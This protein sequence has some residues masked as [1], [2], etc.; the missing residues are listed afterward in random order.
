[1]PIFGRSFPSKSHPFGVIASP[2]FNGV[3]ETIDNQGTASYTLSTSEAEPTNQ[4]GNATQALTVEATREPNKDNSATSA[5]SFA[6][7]ATGESPRGSRI[8]DPGDSAILDDFN[9]ANESPLAGIWTTGGTGSGTHRAL[10]IQSNQVNGTNANVLNLSFINTTY[11]PNTSAYITYTTLSA[12]AATY[13]RL[14]IRASGLSA[15]NHNGYEIQWSNDSNGL[16]L[17][18]MT[19]G[20][21]TL[22]AQDANA[23]MVAGDKIVLEAIDDQ[24]TVYRNGVSV[25]YAIDTSYSG[26]SGNLGL[27][28]R[29]TDG[30][31]DDF[32]GGTVTYR[33][34]HGSQSLTDVYGDLISNSGSGSN[35]FASEKITETVSNSAAAT[36]RTSDFETEAERSTGTG[37]PTISESTFEYILNHGGLPGL[38]GD[39]GEGD[40][41]EGNYGEGAGVGENQRVREAIAETINNS[42][43]STI[44][45]DETIVTPS[46]ADVLTNTGTA[47][48]SLSTE[49]TSE[50][51][52]QSATG[53]PTLSE[54]TS[55]T[56]SNSATSSQTMVD[57]PTETENNQGT[58]SQTLS[59]KI[60]ETS[61]NSATATHLITELEPEA[62]MTNQGTGSPT[63][64]EA[65]AETVSNSASATITISDFQS[66]EER[67]TG[68]GAPTITEVL[69]ESVT[70]SA[71]S[72]QTIAEA[73]PGDDLG[74]TGTGTH[75]FSEA[76]AESPQNS[77]T[78][79]I[80][81]SDFQTEEESNTGTGSPTITEVLSEGA[82]NSATGTQAISEQ[83]PEANLTSVALG[84]QSLSEAE[85]QAINNSAT[86]SQTMA[87]AITESVN[88]SATN[89]QSLIDYQ[90]DA[91]T[92]TGTGSHFTDG[93][94]ISEMDTVAFLAQ[95]FI[96]DQRDVT[97][98]PFSDIST[99]TWTVAPLYEKVDELIVAAGY[100]TETIRSGNNPSNDKAILQLQPVSDPGIDTNH[101]INIEFYKD[102]NETLDF[103][104]N[105]KENGNLIATRTF[106]DVQETSS[107]PRRERIALT[108]LEASA[109]VDYSNLNIELIANQ[110]S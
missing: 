47:T 10:R 62:N 68:T 97:V 28:Y 106:T 43:T 96:D 9:R 101:F 8:G 58:G 69:S 102:G 6:I 21:A 74:N 105:L 83:T 80:V 49:R 7:D 18:S 20:T 16:R 34:T 82:N 72:D 4:S 37:T 100:P 92:N 13:I 53:T 1:M 52:S 5:Q 108:T 35:N 98:V 71:T 30:A 65:T 36:I 25:L 11:G 19:S 85:A 26:V 48:H 99:G 38:N 79:T 42:S 93:E 46:V 54:A 2:A 57:A 23:R 91:P 66:E 22:L 95:H 27:G 86:S 32:G 104:I 51:N 55:E 76:T 60:A 41:G 103:I 61:S 73:Q 67:N 88:N 14:Y 12:A 63:I 44:T 107:V 77:A 110:T 94:K 29:N 45:I 59:E 70:S 109:I 39:Y 81:I 33:D 3:I 17:N 89:T 56:V 15:D 40:Y 78:A 64:S 84:T 31:L 90:L 24:I 75:S 50:S 87:E